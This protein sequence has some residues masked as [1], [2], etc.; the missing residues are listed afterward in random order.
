MVLSTPGEAR[1]RES[2]GTDTPPPHGAPEERP[3]PL[4]L[5]SPRSPVSNIHLLYLPVI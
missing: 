5:M 2:L 4:T 3:A 1:Q